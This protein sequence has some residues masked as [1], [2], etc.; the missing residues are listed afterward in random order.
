MI[1]AFKEYLH[2]RASLKPAYIPYY[3]KWVS[4]CY[5]FLDIDLSSRLMSEQKKQ[6]L[7]HM[8]KRYEDWQVKQ[9]DTALRLFDYF[10]SV[11]GRKVRKGVDDNVNEWK[12]CEEKMREALRLRHR[13]LSTERTYLMW[14]RRFQ[15]FVGVKQPAGLEGRDLQDF[16][17]YLAVEKKITPSTQNQALNAIVFFFRHVLEKNID[18]ELNAVRAKQRRRLPVVLTVRE[19]MTI[20]E[21]LIGTSKLMA[22][23]IYGCGLRLQECLRLRIKDIDLE[24]G[25]II[26]RAGKGDKDRRTVLPEVLKDDLI[27]HMAEI[28]SLYEHDRK[29][30]VNGVWLP[31]ALD[32]KYPKAGKEW[33]WFWLFP[34]KSLA[35]DPRN[36]IVRRHHVHPASIQ[37]ALKVALGKAG[38]AKQASVHT[39][40]HSFATHLLE[41]GY[42][43]RTI[44]ELLGHQNLQTTMIY[45]HVAN[46]NILGVKSP[47]DVM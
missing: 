21:H 46:K 4:A 47:L 39:L 15:G 24:Q 12:Y 18:N 40:R 19:V 16:L 27:R 26:V 2:R 9:A 7:T 33:G 36:L 1:T 5:E 6:F 14:V 29:E 37:K 10:L 20:F 3:L 8:T 38:I 28:R 30:N 41:Q 34:S 13:S 35:V 32:K 17:S 45:T 31:G 43:I 22:M 42:D 11:E 23:L 25:V 44:Q